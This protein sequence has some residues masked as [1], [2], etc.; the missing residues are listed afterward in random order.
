MLSA[1]NKDMFRNISGI[2][3]YQNLRNSIT[4]FIRLS[5]YWEIHAI[6]STE[7]KLCTEES[8][9]EPM[10]QAIIAAFYLPL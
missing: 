3:I 9:L 1:S 6:V 5:F 8:K 2:E 4:V 10:V 7:R